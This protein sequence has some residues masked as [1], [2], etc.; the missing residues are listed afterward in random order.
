MWRIC[1]LADPF[2]LIYPTFEQSV[3]GLPPFHPQHTGWNLW[4][5]DCAQY[6]TIHLQYLLQLTKTK[7][8]PF[9]SFHIAHKTNGRRKE[10]EWCVHTDV[11]P[12]F[13]HG[14]C[15][16]Q[17]II[18]FRFAHTLISKGWVLPPLGIKTKA[19]PHDGDLRY[20][21]KWFTY[22]QIPLFFLTHPSIT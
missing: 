14:E 12:P 22:W 6:Q 15:K 21:G 19:G 1:I 7:Y 11:T 2:F 10:M 3:V 9:K 17:K 20:A 18:L 5:G 8:L 16:S 4:S 13:R